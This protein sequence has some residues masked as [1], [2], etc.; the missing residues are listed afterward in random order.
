MF[1]VR[2]DEDWPGFSVGLPEEPPGFRIGDD[3]SPLSALASRPV[4]TALRSTPDAGV[5]PAMSDLLLQTGGPIGP[6]A[7][8]GFQDRFVGNPYWPGERDHLRISPI[9]PVGYGSPFAPA[10]LPL[11]EGMQTTRSLRSDPQVDVGEQDLPDTAAPGAGES[12]GGIS[13][14]Q[15]PVMVQYKPESASPPF[16][17]PR[18]RAPQGV[19]ASP[20]EVV[21]LPDGST[22][23]DAKSPTGHVMSPKTDLHDVAA[24]G[25]QIGEIYR[26]IRANPA[27]SGGAL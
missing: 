26:S 11:S 10:Q 25:R 16:P 22:I 4:P 3:G 15:S 13:S 12:P 27:T 2:R 24:K 23:A 8:T 14:P 19:D 18:P 6:D 20:G 5:P 17:A 9:V 21:V 1:N 7:M